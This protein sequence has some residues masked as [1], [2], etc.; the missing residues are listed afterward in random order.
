MIPFFY[1][2]HSIVLHILLQSTIEFSEDFIKANFWYFYF[3]SAVNGRYYKSQT[4]NLDFMVRVCYYLVL[5]CFYPLESNWTTSLYVLLLLLIMLV[6]TNHKLPLVAKAGVSHMHLVNAVV[7]EG[8]MN[9]KRKQSN[10]LVH[11]IF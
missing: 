5:F 2:L 10:W 3:L 11:V 7:A 9:H 4:E 1:T 8:I 6:V